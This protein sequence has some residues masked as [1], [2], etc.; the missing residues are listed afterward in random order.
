[1]QVFASERLHETAIQVPPKGCGELSEQI[2]Q[3]HHEARALSLYKPIAGEGNP[4]VMNY[5]GEMEAFIFRLS[6]GVKTSN[7]PR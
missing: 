4:L 1:M 5:L 2:L 6:Q 7:T 3:L